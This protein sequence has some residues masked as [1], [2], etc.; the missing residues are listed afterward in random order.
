[1]SALFLRKNHSFC[2]LTRGL[3]IEWQKYESTPNLDWT[4][5]SALHRIATSASKPGRN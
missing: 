1:V 4:E 3:D 2:H 5:M